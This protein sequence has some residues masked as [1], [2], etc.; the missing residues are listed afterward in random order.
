M[1]NLF[2]ETLDVTKLTIL[3]KLPQDQKFGMK[4]NFQVKVN[5]A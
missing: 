4:L 1:L 2:E 5:H 3:L